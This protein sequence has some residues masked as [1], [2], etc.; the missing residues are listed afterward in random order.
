[1]KPGKKIS[2]KKLMGFVGF[3]IV[4]AALL[5]PFIVFYGPFQALKVMAVGSI[6][7]SRHPQVVRAFLSPA[8]ISKITHE[9]D[10]LGVN[11]Q[12]KI[13][14]KQMTAG[15]G[16]GIQI[17]NIQGQSFRGKV[18]LIKDPK[19]VKVAVTNR[20]G[21]AGEV[22]TH[23][24]QQSGAVAGI[25][26]GGF[27]GPG[28]GG[29]GGF[30]EG[31]T[32]HAG[33]LVYNDIGNKKAQDLIGI[34]DQGKLVIAPMSADELA[35]HHIQEAVTFYGPVLVAN[36]KPVVAG[37]GGIGIGPRTGIGQ[38]ADGTIIFV[39]IDGRQP[40]WSWGATGRQLMNVFLQYH[41]VN[42]VNLDGGSSSEMV[43]QGKIINRLWDIFGERYIPTAFVVMPK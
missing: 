9:Y 29:N 33:K 5:A 10:A 38:T 25:N 14:S 27:N 12:A 24:V 26:A 6:A 8:E 28:W 37:D 20:L 32:V 2:W 31:L 23:L 21:T 13:V 16:S 35:A 7:L 30:P 34:N 1:M 4:F 39:V 17:Q 18:I 22:L 43:Y 41:A 42:A 15:S 40:T 3:N 11:T 36:G 19:R